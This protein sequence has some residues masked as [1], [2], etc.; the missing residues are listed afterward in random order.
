MMAAS[1]SSTSV[2]ADLHGSA[3]APIPALQLVQQRV[4]RQ[5][6]RDRG[7][8]DLPGAHRGDVGARLGLLAHRGA[9]DPVVRIAVWIQALDELVAVV[10]LPEPRHLG[11]G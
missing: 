5:V 1:R 11:A 7:D 6:E 9:A 8:A 10:A 4:I 2:R 3:P